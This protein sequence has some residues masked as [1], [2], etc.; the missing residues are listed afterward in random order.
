MREITISAGFIKNANELLRKIEKDSFVTSKL[1]SA[2]NKEGG[3]GQARKEPIFIRQAMYNN[4]NSL[5]ME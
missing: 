4:I 3:R 2:F 1:H 5:Q